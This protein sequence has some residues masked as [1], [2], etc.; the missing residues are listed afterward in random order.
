MND[1][2]ELRAATYTGATTGYS[3]WKLLIGALKKLV[4]PYQNL[5][6]FI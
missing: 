4:F 3:F 6:L 5:L 2:T 1:E